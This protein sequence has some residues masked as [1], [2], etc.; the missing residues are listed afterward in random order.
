MSQE[1]YA[2]L[3]RELQLHSPIL[4]TALAKKFIRARFRDLRRKRLWSWRIGQSQF[5][6]PD[7]VISGKVNITQNSP[8]IVGVG[9]T[10]DT[11]LIGRQFRAGIN[12]PV[13]TIV[14]VNS[15]T[16]LVLDQPMGNISASNLGYQ[17][18]LAF[19]T[20]PVDCQ[21]LISVRDIFSNVRL[22]LH[23]NQEQLD[24]WDAQ[25]ASSGT[26]YCLAD[27]RYGTNPSL[28]SVSPAVLAVGT[29]GDSLPVLSG[30]YTGRTDSIF[31]ITIATGGVT[32]TATFNWAKDNGT[33]NAGII[34]TSDPQ[35]LQEG[36]LIQFPADTGQ[37]YVQNDVIVCKVRPGLV[38]GTPQYELWPYGFSSRVYP[39]LY[40]KRFPDIDDPNGIVPPFIDGDV[41]VKGALADLCR[42]RG[43]ETRSN[44]M[45][46]LDNAMSFEKEFQAKV[47][48]LEREDDEVYLVDVRYQIESMTALDL[49]PF[50]YGAN[51]A[52]SHGVPA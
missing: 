51:W 48:E 21:D 2:E 40:D 50:P 13:Y 27:F 10:W 52:Q 17:I 23:V 9:T 8:Q 45:Y 44:P 14:D 29:Q 25:R 37:V 43:T 18:F 7:V 49:A 42:W 38:A 39:F 30:V 32:G 26:P 15:N 6:I 11:T 34:S 36:V 16:S 4:P 46:G 3:W 28:G 20:P 19:L 12:S 47:A 5:I 24:S 33:V 1:T 31:V 41:L 35:E 22:T